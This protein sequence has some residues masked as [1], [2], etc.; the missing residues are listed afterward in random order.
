[1]PARKLNF[2][3]FGIKLDGVAMFTPTCLA[4]SDAR[5]LA[6]LIDWAVGIVIIGTIIHGF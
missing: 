1:M 2:F 3:I 6:M 5:P 4:L